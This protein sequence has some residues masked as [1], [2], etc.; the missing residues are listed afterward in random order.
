MKLIVFFKTEEE[1]E[2]YAENIGCDAY[3][4][5]FTD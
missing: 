2:L 1:A 5:K 4:I 3:M